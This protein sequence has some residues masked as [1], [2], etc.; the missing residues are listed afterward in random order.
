M[1]WGG[2]QRA[3]S[4]VPRD[5][6]VCSIALHDRDELRVINSRDEDQDAV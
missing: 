5:Q 4:R 2:E 1:L 3:H 6:D